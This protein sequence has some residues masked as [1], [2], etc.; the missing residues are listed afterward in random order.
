MTTG[1]DVDV[2]A[3][4]GS[5]VLET[6]SGALSAT[7]SW[8]AAGV[9]SCAVIDGSAVGA[10]EDS[11]SACNGCASAVDE[12]VS[13]AEGAGVGAGAGAAPGRLRAALGANFLPVVFSSHHALAESVRGFY[14]GTTHC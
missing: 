4:A 13:G 1:V 2:G 8:V 7:G 11:G 9:G 14:M 10:L 3:G 12:G 5:T 6:G